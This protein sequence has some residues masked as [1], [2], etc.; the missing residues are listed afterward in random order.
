MTK[1]IRILSYE[2]NEKFSG[3][4]EGT[5]KIFWLKKVN[6]R[7]CP[8]RRHPIVTLLFRPN[9]FRLVSAYNY[10]LDNSFAD[11]QCLL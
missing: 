11:G 10:Y 1:K 2:E 7:P 6:F 9:Y 3:V 8:G 4:K 5:K